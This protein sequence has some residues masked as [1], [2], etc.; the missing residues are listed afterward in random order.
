LGARHCR[1]DAEL[2]RSSS[3]RRPERDRLR[4]D[5][6][7]SVSHDLRTPL[8]TVLGTL[9][10]LKAS[11]PEQAEQLAAARGGAERLHRFVGNLLDMV[12]IEAGT[13]HRTTEPVD[14]AEAVA[15]A[16]HDL[17]TAL[18]DH[19]VKLDIA[20][21]LPFVLVD[22]QL[23]HHCLINL[24]ENA[25]K[26]GNPEAPITVSAKRDAAGLALIV[27]DEGPGLPPGEEA[28]IFETFARIEGS[29][30]KGGT[31]LGLAIVKGFAEAMGLAV[32]AANRTDRPGAYF[33]IRFDA[34]QL[35]TS[36]P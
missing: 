13:L 23:F 17:R 29:D 16:T 20:P 9:R 27:M 1:S 25:A 31:G 4:H 30:R 21:D 34:A 3:A 22:P 19:A 15:S 8:T 18:Q 6:L 11:T 5:L 24:I 7:S 35:K 36:A 10:E 26:Y 12:R 14:L 33:T 32:S 28:R 2:D